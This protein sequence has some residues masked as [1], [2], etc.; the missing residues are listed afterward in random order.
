MQ[1][2]HFNPTPDQTFELVGSG[3]YDFRKVLDEATRQQQAGCIEKACNLRFQGF[4]RLMELLPED[5]EIIL[6]WNH[7]NSRAVLE[8]L[9]ATAVDHF[10][11]RDYELSAA[12]LELLMELDPEDHLEAAT[13]LAFDYQAMDEQELFDEV[14]NDVSDKQADR[15]ILLLWAGFRRNGVLPEGELKR[16][17]ERF[18]PYYREFTADEH[19]ADEAY[20]RS[21]ESEHPTA[22]AE[23]RELWLRTESLWQQWPEFIEQLKR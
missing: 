11:I 16:L 1:K 21:I 15:L 13:L 8:L 5:E 20:L 12:Q 10:L 9:H 6:E 17:K 14:I 23:A 22:E 18:A 19:P 2:P 7:R 3:P 4:Q